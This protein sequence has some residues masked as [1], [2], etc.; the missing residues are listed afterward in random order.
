MNGVNPRALDSTF[1]D[2][3]P[4]YYHFLEVIAV[5]VHQPALEQRGASP[6]YQLL[7]LPSTGIQVLRPCG[8]PPPL[9]GPYRQLLSPLFSIV[10]VF[11]RYPGHGLCVKPRRT[12]S[13]LNFAI[14]TLRLTERS[15]TRWTDI[16]KA[17]T[18][19]SNVQCSRN[20]EDRIKWRRIAEAAVAK[21]D[22]SSST[23]TTLSRVND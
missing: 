4:G 21:E 19:T 12:G 15:P 13:L 14:L 23:T 17:S 7:P 16:I 18:Q 6:Q 20:A 1:E 5:K 10:E 2:V 3:G 22:V 9:V 11:T 8:L